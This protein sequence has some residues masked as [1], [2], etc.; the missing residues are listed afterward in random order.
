MIMKPHIVSLAA[1]L[2]CLAGESSSAELTSHHA[3]GSKRRGDAIART[4]CVACHALGASTRSPN[5]GAPAF[6]EVA[7]KY[8]SLR[9]EWE[10]EAISDV[11]HYS[12]PTKRLTAAEIRDLTA[13]VRSLE[14][15]GD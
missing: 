9:L 6:V 15:R 1:L 2:A 10:L 11:G 12:M 3:H 5:A 7:R 13:Y 14:P 4:Q 8:R